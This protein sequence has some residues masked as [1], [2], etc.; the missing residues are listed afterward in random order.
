MR[1]TVLKNKLENALPGRIS[2]TTQI[3]DFLNNI[4]RNG[5]SRNQIV[6]VLSKHRDIVNLGHCVKRGLRRGVYK[7]CMWG[8]KDDWPDGAKIDH[9]GLVIV[10][11]DITIGL[12]DLHRPSSI[13]T[14][15]YMYDGK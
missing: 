12:S 13:K 7:E 9:N 10:P 5:T 3:I 11:D 15:S 1:T 8:W 2:S 4:T 14:I 6:N